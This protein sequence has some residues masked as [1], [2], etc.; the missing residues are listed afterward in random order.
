MRKKFRELVKKKNKIYANLEL[1][2]WDIET[3][4]PV[5]SKPYLSDLV[6]ELS[7]QEYDLFTSDEFVNLV[8][9]L[10]KEKENLSEIEKKE[11]D[12]SMEDIE[13][14]KKIPADE[15]EAYAK[16]TSI[17]QSIWE[18]A[19]S[20]NDFS[21]VKAN[22]EKIFNYNKKFAEYRRKNERNLYDVLLND[23]EK[24]MDTEKLDIFFSEL[25]KEIV[26]FL[27]KIQEKKKTL[28]EEDKINIPVD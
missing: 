22:L 5:K 17:N 2:H 6:A 9:N 24:G 28:K 20:K 16:L 1:L 7:M 12:L 18:E 13:R 21:I 14:M 27:K 3:K 19:K 15:Y 23:Y 25:K 4:T 26:P 11:I 10:N 8:E